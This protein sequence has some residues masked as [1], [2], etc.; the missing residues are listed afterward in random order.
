MVNSEDRNTGLRNAASKGDAAKVRELLAG[1]SDVNA[2]DKFGNTA[3]I[4]AALN[5]HAEVV[6]VLLDSGAGTGARNQIGK[7]A[8]DVAA[9]NGHAAVVELLDAF[10]SRPNEALPPAQAVRER[11]SLLRAAHEGDADA[12][13]ALLAEGTDVD[14]RDDQQWTPLMVATVRG[15]AGVVKSLLGGGADVNARNAKGWGALM[16]AVSLGD[17]EMLRVLL[18]GGADSNLR[19]KEGRTPL[20]SA[21]DE[22]NVECLKILLA[23][24][25]DVNAGDQHGETAATIAARHGHTEAFDLL[26]RAGAE[27]A[28]PVAAPALENSYDLK[29][30]EEAFRSIWREQEAGGAR[31]ARDVEEAGGAT[32]QPRG[33]IVETPTTPDAQA[34]ALAQPRPESLERLIAALEALRHGEPASRA[35]S[36]AEVA[37][38]ILLTLP[39]AA[40]L[41]GLSRDRLRQAA[42]E[43]TLKAQMIGR[44][45]RIKRADLDEYVRNL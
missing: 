35:P 16:L 1:A 27:S 39:E 37:H 3:L 29:N 22:N 5:G 34:L 11:P 6:R 31:E 33:A 10:K 14:A 17:A 20:I 38:K 45:W 4:Y 13:G 24:G 44:R 18:S 12:V 40:V 8:R 9:K 30:P 23:H 15:H 42:R 36:A 7:T 43:G 2:T 21:A 19:D 41:T 25:A 32:A 26:C 28:A